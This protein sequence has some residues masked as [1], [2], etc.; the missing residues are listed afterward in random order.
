MLITVNYDGKRFKPKTP[1]GEHP[2]TLAL[3]GFLN[4]GARNAMQL[5]Y[6]AREEAV[7][8]AK[9]MYDY[10]KYYG[11]QDEI[12]ISREDRVITVL[13]IEGGKE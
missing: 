3:K 6:G 9:L 10:R 12:R 8:G 13:K 11:L 1:R 2:A 4:D 5:T 7:Y